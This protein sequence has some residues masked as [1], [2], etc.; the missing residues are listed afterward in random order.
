M[1]VFENWSPVL[2]SA[3]CLTSGRAS[4]TALSSLYMKSQ[5]QLRPPALL[6]DPKHLKFCDKTLTH[7]LL[8]QCL[9][10][11]WLY[12][13]FLE[14]VMNIFVSMCENFKRH[15]RDP[16]S[17]KTDYHQHGLPPLS[18][19]HESPFPHVLGRLGRCLMRPSYSMQ[20]CCFGCHNTHAAVYVCEQIIWDL[21]C[22]S[23]QYS[24]EVEEQLIRCLLNIL[25]NVSPLD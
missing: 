7:P 8:H 9:D 17:L 24:W 6:T 21:N 12:C 22:V 20:P 2:A 3:L 14:E 5:L 25:V 4:C 23:Y 11:S 19:K 1:A 18:L 13:I 15:L 10:G 16:T